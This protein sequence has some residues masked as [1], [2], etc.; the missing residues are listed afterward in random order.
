MRWCG[1]HNVDC[2]IGLAR[3]TK[4]ERRGDPF[5]Q[6]AQQQH[7]QAKEKQW[8]FA[9]FN[10]AAESWDRKRWVIHKAEYG[11]HGWWQSPFHR[12]QPKR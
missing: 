8:I 11:S 10:Y 1:R 5:M 7:E 2:A 4:L 9:D 3:N 6:R 12:H